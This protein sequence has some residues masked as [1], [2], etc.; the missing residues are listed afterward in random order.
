MSSLQT[1]ITAWCSALPPLGARHRAGASEA[2]APVAAPPTVPA[3]QAPEPPSHHTSPPHLTA[4]LVSSHSLDT[5][6]VGGPRDLKVTLTVRNQ[7]EDSYRTQVT[8]F[9]P[10]GLS[11]R[12]VSASQVATSFSDSIGVCCPHPRGCGRWTSPP[13]PLLPSR[14]NA[15]RDPGAWPVSLMS[16]PKSLRP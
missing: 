14:T 3:P 16:P 5:L 7:G 12:K 4:W 13:L 11:Y 9:Y 6:V 10:S 8:F 2:G 1:C 15:P